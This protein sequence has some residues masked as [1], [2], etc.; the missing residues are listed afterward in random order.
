M[1][2]DRA[3]NFRFGGRQFQ[4]VG[5]SDCLVNA[6]FIAGCQLFHLTVYFGF[7]ESAKVINSISPS[8]RVFDKALLKLNFRFEEREK[9]ALDSA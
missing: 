3:E 1:S 4:H 5:L 8:W 6:G 2:Q 7:K 9:L